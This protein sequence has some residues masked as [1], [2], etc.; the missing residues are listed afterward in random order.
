MLPQKH[1]LR[2]EKEIK[3]LFAKG[4]SVFG[5]SVIIRYRRNDFNF[6]RFAFVVGTKVSKKAVDRNKIKRR[7]RAIVYKQLGNIMSGVDIVFLV[8][9]EAL[10][11]SFAKLET[12]V[13][14]A[15]AKAKL[16]RHD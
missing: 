14:E 3:T 10:G 11:A 7:L 4:K 8:R 6:P 5:N 12:Q 1:R 2:L 16:V 15:L 13:H 9:K